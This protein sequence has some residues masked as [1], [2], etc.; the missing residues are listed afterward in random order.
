MFGLFFAVAAIL[1]NAGYYLSQAMCPLI[2]SDA[3]YFLDAFVIKWSGEGFHSADCFVKR[4]ITDHAQPLNKILLYLNYRIFKLD[5]VV[6]ALCGFAGLFLFVGIALFL[7]IRSADVR[8]HH[9]IASAMFFVCAL[10]A[11]TS[12][13][14]TEFYTWSLVTFELNYFTLSVIAALAIWACANSQKWGLSVSLVL[15]LVCIMVLSGDTASLI[16]WA[17][18]FPCILYKGWR[19]QGR[20]RRLCFIILGVGTAIVVSY[21]TII[22][23]TS[24]HPAS[25]CV[26]SQAGG[27]LPGFSVGIF[28]EAFRI[29]FSSAVIHQMHLSFVGSATGRLIEWLVSVVLFFFY[30]RFF[31]DLILSRINFSVYKYFV[32]FVLMHASVSVVLIMIGRVPEY[33]VQ[34]LGQP[35]YILIYQEIPFALLL[36]YSL[37]KCWPTQTRAWCFRT[38]LSWCFCI[39]FILLQSF[40]CFKAYKALPLISR[41]FSEQ[42][43]AI[44][45]FSRN[46]EASVQDKS[47]ATGEICRMPPDYRNRLIQFLKTE[48]LNLFNSG[49]Q[50]SHRFFPNQVAPESL[51]IENWGPRSIKGNEGTEQSNRPLGL[52]IKLSENP[53]P[54]LLSISL[55]NVGLPTV[56]DGPVIAAEVPAALL[57]SRGTNT[58][59]LRRKWSDYEQKVGAFIVY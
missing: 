10:M 22:Y 7:F 57:R 42:A 55:N 40:F 30:V 2:R 37:S 53:D 13:N 56:Q 46:P 8:R 1:L 48:N 16:A 41:Y 3:W 49:F 45:Y 5:F 39:L 31:V 58:L 52:W 33:G 35:R 19:S 6:E 32:M 44:G 17:A 15:L 51:C 9:F 25:F 4:S 24:I 43:V 59:L 14:T 27:L 34:Y 23:L 18:I 12:M 11:L 26:K 28:I 21:Y 20:P 54:Q 38:F 36:D 47:G 29:V 50:W